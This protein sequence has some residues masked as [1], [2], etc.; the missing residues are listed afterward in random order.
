MT[1]T[2]LHM[3][4]FM[5]ILIGKE[6]VQMYETILE[7]NNKPYQNNEELPPNQIAKGYDEVL[8]MTP[9]D[10]YGPHHDNDG[11]T[12]P[13]ISKGYDMTL[14]DAYG[15]ASTQITSKD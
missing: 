4:A 2:L 8:A 14:N 6:A 12:S 7:V 9:N 15:Y 10:A 3:T 1:I 13:Q 5:R 11:Q